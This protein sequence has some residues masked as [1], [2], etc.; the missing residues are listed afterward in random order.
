MQQLVNVIKLVAEKYND[1][2][3]CILSKDMLILEY[4]YNINNELDVYKSME[5]TE[6]ENKLNIEFIPER[7]NKIIRLEE[8]EDI[9]EILEKQICKKEH[10]S[11]EI[12]AI[13]EIILKK[14][15]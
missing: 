8:L 14:Q 15:K 5:I 12:H 13:K 3:N 4:L 10:S 6:F 11:S 1:K 2:L 9:F 7:T